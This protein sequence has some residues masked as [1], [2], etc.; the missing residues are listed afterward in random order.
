MGRE[1]G[2]AFRNG[3]LRAIISAPSDPSA[4]AVRLSR[5]EG[6]SD[7]G[8]GVGLGFSFITRPFDLL[9][10]RLRRLPQAAPPNDRVYGGACSGVMRRYQGPLVVEEAW[11]S[12]LSAGQ[13]H[14]T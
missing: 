4:S 11:I 3:N 9:S 12:S 7:C 1:N 14:T 13:K 6:E 10:E 2:R 8:G 5:W